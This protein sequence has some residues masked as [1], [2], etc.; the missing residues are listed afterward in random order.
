[1]DLNKLP[2]RPRHYA[3]GTKETGKIPV[4]EILGS[5]VIIAF[6]VGVVV[7]NLHFVAKGQS[8]CRQDHGQLFCWFFSKWYTRKA[9]FGLL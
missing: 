3:Y 1:M 7:L 8:M 4:A 9:L 5:A 6:A 2:R